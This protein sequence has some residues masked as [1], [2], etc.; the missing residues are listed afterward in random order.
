MMFPRSPSPVEAHLFAQPDS[1][2]EPRDK[3][4]MKG[5]SG[6]YDSVVWVEG[7]EYDA[8]KCTWK[9]QVRD[10]EGSLYGWVVQKNLKAA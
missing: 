5:S 2:F 3:A 9:Y 7:K 4:W 1:K 10:S 8:V 6:F